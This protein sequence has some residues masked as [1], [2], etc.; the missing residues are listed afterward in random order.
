V[1]ASPPPPDAY[2]R[3]LLLCLLAG[4]LLALLGVPLGWMIGSMVASGYLV[5]R[6]A[7][8]V[9]ALARPAGLVVL[10]LALGQAF[11][12]PVLEATAAAL[13]AMLAGGLV[14]LLAGIAVAP[15]YRRVARCDGRTAFFATVPGGVVIMATLALRAGAALP[16]VTLA[17]SVRMALVVLAYPLLMGLLAGPG[18]TSAY[19][20]VLPAVLPAVHWAGLPLLLGAGGVAALLGERLHVSNAAMLAPCLLAMALSASGALPSAVPAWLVDAAQVAMGA[21]LGLF[22][23]REGVGSAPRRSLLAALV[24]GL[25]V[26]GLLVAAGLAIGWISGLPSAAVVLGLAPGGMPEMALTA[27]ALTLAVPL[28]LG[29]HLVRVVLCSLLVLPLWRAVSALGLLR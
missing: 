25:A 7:V 3:T 12:G 18:V 5:L 13:P 15:L 20:A 27:Q 23:A 26:S 1:T 2:L 22:L 10:G 9:P 6:D 4:G 24:A 11:T 21:S 19:T 29:F 8:A 17:Q 28:V 14:V 16:A